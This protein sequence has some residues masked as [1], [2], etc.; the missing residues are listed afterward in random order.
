MASKFTSITQLWNRYKKQMQSD[1]SYVSSVTKNDSLLSKK[2]F[3]KYRPL[4]YYKIKNRCVLSNRAR[5]VF[6][7]LKLTRMVF[8]NLASHGF[9]NG[10]KKQT[11]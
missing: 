3:W 11:W 10:I 2:F 7:K 8:K 1:L 4:S 9:L 6:Y 5:A